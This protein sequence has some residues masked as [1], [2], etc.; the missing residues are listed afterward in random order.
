MRKCLQ[1]V[2]FCPHLS[3]VARNMHSL[4]C[5]A[6]CSLA[7]TI[8]SIVE[9]GRK[10]GRQAA[11]RLAALVERSDRDRVCVCLCA[12]ARVCVQV[13]MGDN[14][15]TCPELPSFHR[16]HSVKERERQWHTHAQKTQ[17][18]TQHRYHA[19]PYA[20]PSLSMAISAN[21]LLEGMSPPPH[22]HTIILRV[23]T[24][25]TQTTINTSKDPGVNWAII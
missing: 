5:T 16:E 24:H 4:P 17:S 19:E 13:D 9:A 10:K 15:A 3:T 2:R 11:R 18:Q 23:Y 12:R 20:D 14:S 21:Q 7:G 8:S 1:F 6:D 25:A 22:T